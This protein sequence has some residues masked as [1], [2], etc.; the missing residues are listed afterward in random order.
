MTLTT[1]AIT[2]AALATLTLNYPLAGFAL[3]FISH[4]ILDAIPHWD[5]PLRSMKKDTENQMNNNMTLNKD[6][7]VDLMRIGSDALLGI[8]AAWVLFGIFHHVSLLVVMCGAIGAM[9]PDALQ[10]VYMKWP[11]EPLVSLQKFHLYMHAKKDLNDKPFMG[12]VSQLACIL[13]FS[14][15]F[16]WI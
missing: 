6:F 11:H 14:I 12:I 15:I 5:Y 8:V 9:T 3:G 10:F 2:G 7:L 13:I 16:L 1:H 4:F